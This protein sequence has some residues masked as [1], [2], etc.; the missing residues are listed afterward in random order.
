MLYFDDGVIEARGR[1]IMQLACA[2]VL[3]GTGWQ[4]PS[5]LAN[6]ANKTLRTA[7]PLALVSSSAEDYA[8]TY[9]TIVSA[10]TGDPTPGNTLRVTIDDGETSNEYADTTRDGENSFI[11]GLNRIVAAAAAD[12]YFAVSRDG[13]SLSLLALLAGTAANGI[14]VTIAWDDA[15]NGTDDSDTSGAAGSSTGAQQV[16]VFYLDEIGTRN[17]V[18]VDLNGVGAVLPGVQ[19]RWVQRLELCAGL[20]PVGNIIAYIDET[21]VEIMVAGAAAS[22]EAAY[23]VPAGWRLA[24]VEFT[25]SSADAAV[26]K[27]LSNA[28]EDGPV[29]DSVAFVAAEFAVNTVP[30]KYKPWAQLGVF[31]ELTVLQLWVQGA[32][33]AIVRATAGGRLF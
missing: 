24:V 29:T 3:D 2:Y 5:Y 12:P 11:A 31:G 8:A 10:M 27:L 1:D 30:Y 18:V 4:F 33:G 17:S 22:I 21:D 28:A 26:V 6:V 32:D 13:T 9:R 23:C 16:R 15:D 20:V 14:T 7:A 25:G 19:A